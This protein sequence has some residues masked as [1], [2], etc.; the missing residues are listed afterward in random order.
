MKTKTPQPF[1]WFK[2]EACDS[3]ADKLAAIPRGQ[4]RIE[5]YRDEK[6]AMWIQVRRVHPDGT[7]AATADLQDPP[8]DNDSL[9]CP[10]FC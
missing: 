6:G 9:I 10:P 1:D 5:C 8:P 3:I 7:S 4:R 2:P